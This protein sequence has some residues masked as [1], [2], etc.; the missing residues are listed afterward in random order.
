MGRSPG[1]L[2]PHRCK[3]TQ[4][5]KRRLS[6]PPNEDKHSRAQRSRRMLTLLLLRGG[7]QPT[8]TALPLALSGEVDGQHGAP[9]IEPL[10]LFAPWLVIDAQRGDYTQIGNGVQSALVRSP[11]QS[12]SGTHQ[13]YLHPLSYPLLWNH[14]FPFLLR[15]LNRP[16]FYATCY[17]RDAAEV[18]EFVTR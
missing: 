18:R 17:A 13:I 1:R 12:R 9:R 6:I 14:R 5:P 7:P 10:P 15:Q 11:H 2:P 16:T 3:R 4:P 8:L